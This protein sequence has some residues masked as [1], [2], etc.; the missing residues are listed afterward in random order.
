MYVYDYNTALTTAIKNISDKEMIRAFPKLIEYL[1][2]RGNNL[3]LYFMDNETPAASKMTM[4]TMNI[5]YQS[6][7]SSN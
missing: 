1:K 3:G 2:S 7:T 5:K 6:V 4:A